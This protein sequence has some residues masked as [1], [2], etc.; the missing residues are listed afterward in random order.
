M[1]TSLEPMVENTL[2]TA[3]SKN[4]SLYHQFLAVRILCWVK[5]KKKN[6]EDDRG[7]DCKSKEEKGFLYSS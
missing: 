3:A 1:D 5:T 4:L 6:K 7:G 2:A